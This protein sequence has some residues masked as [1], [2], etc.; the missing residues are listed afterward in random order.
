MLREKNGKLK[1]KLGKWVAPSNMLRRRWARF[2]SPS[3]DALLRW[4]GAGIARH[5]AAAAQLFARRRFRRPGSNA[6]EWGQPPGMLPAGIQRGRVWCYAAAASKEN[7][8]I[9]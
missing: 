5:S 2:Y 9:Y 6:E 7:M 3:Q 8:L 4:A 1:A